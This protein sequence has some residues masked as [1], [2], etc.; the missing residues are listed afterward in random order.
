[1]KHLLVVLVALGIL[2][3]AVKGQAPGTSVGVSSAVAPVYPPLAL[4]AG[5]T[6][7]VR[8][9]V[10]INGDGSVARADAVDGK[11]PL[12]QATLE[13]ARRWKFEPQRQSTEA[14]LTFSFQIVPNGTAAED[15]TA[16]F[17]PPYRIEV[18][19]KLP[20]ATVNYGG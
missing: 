17:M 8:V 4:S 20:E 11:E 14:M 9:R 5:V 3:L 1:M 12:K 2:S 7:E 19:R 13:A 10:A 18:R 16:I 15:T 6:G